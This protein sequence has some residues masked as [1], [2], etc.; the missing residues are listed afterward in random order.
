MTDLYEK[1]K[2][3]LFEQLKLMDTTIKDISDSQEYRDAQSYNAGI[4]TAIKVL[5]IHKEELENK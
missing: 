2:K 1:M 3:E 5:D 4:R